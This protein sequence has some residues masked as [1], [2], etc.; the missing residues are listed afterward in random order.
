MPAP[1]RIARG[2]RTEAVVVT[3]SDHRKRR[4]RPGRMR[5]LSPLRRDRRGRGGGDRG[6][7]AGIEAGLT[8]RGLQSAMPAGRRPQCGRL[9]P[10][11]S[12]CQ[13]L[14]HSRACDGG[15]GPLATGDHR[16]H[17]Q[18]RDP[19][20]DGGCRREGFRPTD[21][22]SEIRWRGRRSGA[23]RCGS[24]GCPDATLIADATPFNG[25]HKAGPVAFIS[26]PNANTNLG[27]LCTN[28]NTSTDPVSCN[29]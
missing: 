22:E 7:P 18:P 20:R 28:P 13:A 12:R 1:S 24:Q 11:G 15:R 5:P 26:V 16:L 27:P 17:D 4:H 3:A 2:S 25:E 9:R 6:S 23:N 19:R 29:P 8:A 21:P 10:V 14:R